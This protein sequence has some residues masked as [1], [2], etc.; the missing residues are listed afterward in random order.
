MRSFWN[1][2]EIYAE[3]LISDPPF[4]KCHFFQPQSQ[5]ENYQIVIQPKSSNPTRPQLLDLLN[6][7]VV[8]NLIRLTFLQDIR[9]HT[10]ILKPT[11]FVKLIS[12]SESCG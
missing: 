2:W 9:G 10:Q 6:P 1:R 4:P 7:F 12:E 3:K 5:L 8:Y 11:V